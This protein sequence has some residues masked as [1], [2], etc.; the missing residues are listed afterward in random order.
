MS[1]A[2]ID[3]STF[4][5]DVVLLDEDSDQAEWHR[6]ILPPAGDAFDRARTVRSAMPSRSWWEDKS[7][8]AVGIEDP[9]GFNAGVIY[10]IQ[11]GILQCL[12]PDVLVQPWI[13]SAWRKA[14][15]LKGNATKEAVQLRAIDL[16]RNV[17]EVAYCDGESQDT[18]DAFCIAHATRSVLKHGAS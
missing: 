5:V 7:V 14:V 10:R 9:R 1:I 15:G 13:P 12:L 17:G 6:F 3:F 2:G 8:I 4:A 16:W 11:G 18:F